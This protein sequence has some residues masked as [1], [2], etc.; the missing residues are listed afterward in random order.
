[1]RALRLS[2]KAFSG[3][4]RRPRGSLRLRLNRGE[5]PGL[6]DATCALRM[7]GGGIAALR[8]DGVNVF[9]ELRPRC[10][11]LRNIDPCCGIC[12]N[13]LGPVGE[14][15]YSSIPPSFAPTLDREAARQLH[16]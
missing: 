15:G 3:N 7:K 9:D 8:S 4:E 11:R 12:R 5:I 6:R 2:R 16:G 10:R 13:G 1:M 14:R